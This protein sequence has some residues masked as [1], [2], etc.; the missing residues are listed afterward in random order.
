ML[1]KV[2]V[3]RPVARRRTKARATSAETRS[4]GEATAAEAGLAACVVEVAGEVEA[5]E[6]DDRG[7]REEHAGGEG[8][9]SGEG[10]D[11][12]VEG[13]VGE[14]DEGG[15]TGGEDGVDGG[16]SNGH[17]GDGAEGGEDEAFGK[18][19]ADQARARCAEG[20]ADGG[21]AETLASAGHEQIGDVGAT[22]EEDEGDSAEEEQEGAAHFADV[23]G[24]KGKEVEAEVGHGGAAVEGVDLA[25]NVVGFILGEGGCAA[26]AE[27]SDDM[28][29]GGAL[30]IP[31]AD[32][33][34][35]IDVGIGRDAGVVRKEEAEVCGED[36]DDGGF[37]PAKADELADD[38]GVGAE[39]ADPDR[40][41]EDD[42]VGGVGEIVF[43]AEEAAEGGT[44]RDEGQEVG[45]G[46]GDFD[47]LGIAFA[48]EGTVGDPDAG[49]LIEL[50]CALAEVVELETGEGGTVGVAEAGVEDGEAIG[51][52]VGHR[53]EE[54]G[55]DEAED[56]GVGADADGQREDG[57]SGKG[58]AAT[59]LA[60][61]VA[62]ILGEGFECGPGA[63]VADGLLD[64]LDAAA[65]T[66]GG[67]AGFFGGH[68]GG[69]A[70]VGEEAGVGADF[71]IEAML[72]LLL[73]E[74]VAD[75][76][77]QPG[78]ECHRTSP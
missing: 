11:A 2:R 20:G 58:G 46:V 55:V 72:D 52:G 6:R 13:D 76:G 25:G 64:L 41:G 30:R 53:A 59:Q 4:A 56:G 77:A 68:A 51:A 14:I 57:E 3:S 70:F 71:G 17:C 36:A 43:G 28:Q 35:F 65:V 63:M 75:G 40:V 24:L 38:G 61:G 9:G 78:S 60:E 26:V 39:A 31:G 33:D 21:F 50:F 48:G 49:D 19:L 74:Q 66:Q 18:E 54:N 44:G 22:D 73:V 27:A 69:D 45:G 5:A 15:W 23:V 16:P 47:L 10:E 12:R 32:G 1:T 37:V 8:D 7:E 62:E 67:A 42:D 34:G 29:E